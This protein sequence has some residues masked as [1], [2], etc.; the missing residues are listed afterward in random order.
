[1]RC[2][3]GVDVHTVREEGGKRA[4]DALRRKNKGRV[5]VHV[6]KLGVPAESIFTVGVEGGKTV[7]RCVVNVD[8]IGVKSRKGTHHALRWPEEGALLPTP[9]ARTCARVSV[10]GVHFL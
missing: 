4:Y 1:L 7:L 9:V 2:F 3:F 8:G 6:Y 10:W 5:E